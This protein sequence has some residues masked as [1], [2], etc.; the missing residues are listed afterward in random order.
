MWRQDGGIDSNMWWLMAFRESVRALKLKKGKETN[1]LQS[2]PSHTD[3]MLSH[4]A[5]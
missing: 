3:N 5:A 1:E 2:L 4:D